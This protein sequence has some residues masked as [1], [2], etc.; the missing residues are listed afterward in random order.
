MN[1]FVRYAIATLTLIFTPIS[2]ASLC[3]VNS[4]VSEEGIWYNKNIYLLEVKKYCE[5]IQKNV[6]A[7]NI[8]TYNGFWHKGY[9]SKDNENDKDYSIF[10]FRVNKNDSTKLDVVREE[11]KNNVNTKD[12]SYTLTR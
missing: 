10:W 11:F 3:A 1:K 8:C 7:G 6:C 2:H 5:V 12:V 4:S 9:I